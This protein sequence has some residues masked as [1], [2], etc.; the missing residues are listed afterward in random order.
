MRNYD[1]RLTAKRSLIKGDKDLSEVRK[2]LITDDTHSRYYARNALRFDDYSLAEKGIMGA[3]PHTN[4]RRE[5]LGRES[6]PYLMGI[7]LEVEHSEADL[8]SVTLKRAVDKA[9]RMHLNGAHYCCYDGSLGN[10]FEIVTAPRSAH[11]LRQS[12]H[13]YYLLLQALQKEGFRSHDGGH[14]GL[15]VH[16]SRRAL[17]DEKWNGLRRFLSKHGR[18][19]KAISRRDS[20]GY[21]AFDGND[22]RNAGRYSALNLEPSNTAEFRFFRGTLNWK[23]FIM[24]IEVIMSLVDY[25]RDAKKLNVHDWYQFMTKGKYK[26][27]ADRIQSHWDS[28]SA[29]LASLPRP[30]RQARP[31]LT[32]LTP[33]DRSIERRRRA[34]AQAQEVRRIT[35]MLTNDVMRLQSSQFSD[36]SMYVPGS[37]GMRWTARWNGN[38]GVPTRR[39][40]VPVVV[41]GYN[42]RVRRIASRL[43]LFC[44]V[45]IPTAEVIA[46]S[47][48]RMRSSYGWGN[49]RIRSVVDGRGY[50]SI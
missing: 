34:E 8:Q 11:E 7:E 17:S 5:L 40:C 38:S 29:Y 3:K 32:D 44:Y 27:A 15:H 22:R 13:H 16:I 35:D 26:V 19:F 41:E 6:A 31:R 12:Y 47:Q 23:S 45:T 18:L 43:S 28:Y 20:F 39:L 33:H 50:G 46:P 21:C 36:C 42:A 30:V 24:S 14:C 48:I 4:Y 1:N 49:R 37:N 2:A 10:G 9:L 25:A